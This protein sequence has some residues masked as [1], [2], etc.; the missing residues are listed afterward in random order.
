ML[1]DA[2]GIQQFKK[3]HSSSIIRHYS[4]FL[5]FPYSDTFGDPECGG[6]VSVG[7]SVLVPSF[8]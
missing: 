6:S 5:C 2:F 1:I 4:H 3:I 7:V 8:V